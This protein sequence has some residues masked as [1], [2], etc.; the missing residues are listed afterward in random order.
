MSTQIDDGGLAFPIPSHVDKLKSRIYETQQGMTLRDWFAGQALGD[1][2]SHSMRDE[3][4]R[5][6]PEWRD[7]VALECYKFADAMIEARKGDRS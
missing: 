7:A 1:I 3:W 5:S 6:G 2:T 4:A